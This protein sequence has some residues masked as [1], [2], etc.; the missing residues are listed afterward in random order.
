[1]DEEAGRKKPSG[2]EVGM[3]LDALSLDELKARIELL[4][5]EITRLHLEIEKK[6][7]TRS[8]AENIFNL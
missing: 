2:H 1:M 6:D 7:A 5:G 3:A 4:E 8:A